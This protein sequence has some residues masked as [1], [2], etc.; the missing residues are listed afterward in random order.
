MDYGEGYQRDRQTPGPE[1]QWGT[2]F[3]VF[4]TAGQHF[5]ARLTLGWALHSTPVT[6][7]GGIQAYFSMGTQF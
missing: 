1:R 3:G 6:S 7:A 5:E 4:L 2:G